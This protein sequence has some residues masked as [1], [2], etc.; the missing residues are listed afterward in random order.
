MLEL[1]IKVQA[2]IFKTAIKKKCVFCE[3]HISFKNCLQQ[4]ISDPLQKTYNKNTV[5]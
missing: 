2:E 5:R 3:L 1:K 4:N